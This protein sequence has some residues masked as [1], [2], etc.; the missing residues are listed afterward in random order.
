MFC[1]CVSVLP[2]GVSIL[3]NTGGTIAGNAIWSKIKE[4]YP[5]QFPDK[6]APKRVSP[7][8]EIPKVNKVEIRKR[9]ERLHRELE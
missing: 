9:S 4:K 6:S 1:G 3:A 7:K 8:K 2:V 5:Q